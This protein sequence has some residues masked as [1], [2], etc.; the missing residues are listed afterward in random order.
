MLIILFVMLGQA[1]MA[2][3]E[4]REDDLAM[5]QQI[6]FQRM[7]PKTLTP[8]VNSRDPVVRAQTA[9]TLGRMKNPGGLP[10][11]RLLLPDPVVEVRA[12]AAFAMG[13][14][15][16][17][18]RSLL[19]RLK[20]ED[21]PGV[22]SLLVEAIGQSC[23]SPEC[24]EGI[25]WAMNEEPVRLLDNP[26]RVQA[27][28]AIGRMAYRDVPGSRAP[29]IVSVLLQQLSHPS[30]STRQASAFALECMHLSELPDTMASQLYAEASEEPDPV[31]RA[32]LIDA[33]G[34]LR[35]A[36][37]AQH[38]L[39]Q[40]AREDT[41]LSVRLSVARTAKTSQWSGVVPMLS[42]SDPGVRRVSIE[43]VGAI[44][45]LDH[46]TLLSPF[47]E[48]MKD[49]PQSADAHD[50][51]AALT[52]LYSA[53]IAVPLEPWMSEEW[54]AV[55]R[56]TAV[57]LSSSRES[58]EGSGESATSS[59][60]AVKGHPSLRLAPGPAL[61]EIRSARVKTTRGE[62]IIALYP[63][64]APL[65]V[66]SF[67]HQAE[68]GLFDGVPFSRVEPGFIA[69]IA[70]LPSEDRVSEAELLPTEFNPLTHRRG[71]VSMSPA[72]SSTEPHS[73][74][75][76]T[77]SPQPLLDGRY[78]SFGLVIAGQQYLDQLGPGD[79]IIEVVLERVPT[80]ER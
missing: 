3:P 76:I 74:W 36:P 35:G 57:R 73:T 55:I 50:A 2:Q 11:L 80:T 12:E 27:S 54:P 53:G 44:P 52:A 37:A 69:E 64:H 1:V 79:Q 66:W 30:K 68:E 39:Y 26:L 38:A 13:L 15:P 58:A 23:D 42:D 18:G 72:R 78:T 34:A 29:V 41:A 22:R 24:V 31:T 33:T 61:M 48:A 20:I 47:L 67:A 71:S 40:Q 60:V 43:S 21:D 25:L 77:L 49:S 62:V 10:P 46:L 70:P 5:I 75:F 63:E 14:I 7:A 4:T 32:R 56:S 28:L 6:E 16:G 45:G 17:G 9:R 51:A 59:S 19:S 65:T 8:F